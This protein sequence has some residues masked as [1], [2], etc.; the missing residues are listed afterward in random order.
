MTRTALWL[1]AGAVALLAVGLAIGLS[2][3][4]GDGTKQ[5]VRPTTV[6][7]E[8]LQSLF[9]EA[10]VGQK[11]PDVLAR[12]PEPYQHYRDNLGEDCYEWRGA[13]LYNLCF[14]VGVLHLKTTF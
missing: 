9:E 12:F 5:P 10:T 7:A 4:Y 8:Q 2:L 13:S 3:A 11:E 14:R 1:T 6:S